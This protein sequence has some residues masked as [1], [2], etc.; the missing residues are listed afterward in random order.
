M[1]ADPDPALFFSGFR[2][3]KKI[4]ITYPIGTFTSVF[5]G[6]KKIFRSPNTA[7]NLSFSSS[8][9]LLMEGSGGIR[10]NKQAF[11]GSRK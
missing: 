2:D 7:E 3:V 6:M 8:L 5:K 9:C 10:S 4:N 1:D 11:K